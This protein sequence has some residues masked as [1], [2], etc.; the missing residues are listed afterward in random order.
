MPQKRFKP[1]TVKNATSKAKT[2]NVWTIFDTRTKQIWADPRN[3]VSNW[4]DVSW[5]CDNLNSREP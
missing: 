4:F 1:V 2:G 3:R 5:T